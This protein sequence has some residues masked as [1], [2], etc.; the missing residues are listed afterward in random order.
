MSGQ[1]MYHILTDGLDADNILSFLKSK[2]FRFFNDQ[3]KTSG[4]NTAIYKMP[5]VG[6]SQN[7]TDAELYEL[8]GLTEEEIEYIEHSVSV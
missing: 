8:F 6:D 3:S 5:W 7:W 1:G 4:F 2:L